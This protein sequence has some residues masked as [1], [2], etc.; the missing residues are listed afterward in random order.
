MHQH[1]LFDVKKH[2]II[3]AQMGSVKLCIYVIVTKLD[4]V[5]QVFGVRTNDHAALTTT[6]TVRANTTPSRS[7]DVLDGK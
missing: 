3:T 5:I 4:G 7:T 6:T 1:P 2:S